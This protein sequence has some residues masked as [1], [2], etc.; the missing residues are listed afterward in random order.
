MSRHRS[1]VDPVL[2]DK[3]VRRGEKRRPS[4]RHPRSAAA[5]RSLGAVDFPPQIAV[6]VVIWFN[7]LDAGI[8]GGSGVDVHEVGPRVSSLKIEAT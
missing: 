7:P 5:Y 3:D 4:L 2:N 6:E 1:I 8:N